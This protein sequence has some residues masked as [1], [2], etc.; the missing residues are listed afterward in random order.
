MSLT[1]KWASKKQRAL[2]ILL[3]L[4]RLYPDATC[5]LT[6]ET[7]VQLLVATILSAQCTDERVNKVTPALFARFPDAKSLASAD[8]EEIE[9]LIRSTGFYR[10]KAKNIQGACQKIITEFAGEVPQ[11]MEQLLTLPGVARKTANVVSAHA[12]GNIQGVTVDTHV[13]R[14]SGR[15]GLTEETDPVKI[16]RDLMRILPQNDWENYSISIIFH[17][18]AVCKARN[19]DCVVCELSHL[20]PSAMLPTLDTVRD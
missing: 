2:E 11:Q 17:G 14:L 20:C 10:N 7:P 12:Y 13:K 6:Y 1:R 18:R 19:P 3:I 9:I 4:K 15:L 16:E 5:S 8:R